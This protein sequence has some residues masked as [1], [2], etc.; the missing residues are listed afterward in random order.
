MVECRVA[1]RWVIGLAGLVAAFAPAAAS[2]Q[3]AYEAQVL[4]VL[5]AVRA[6]PAA[7]A[8]QLRTFRSYFHGASYVVPGQQVRNVT[9]EGVGAVDEAIAYLSRQRALRPMNAADT[10]AAAA[11]DHV[12]EQGEAG[13]IGHGGEDGSSPGDRVRRHGGG[14]YVAEVIEYGASDPVDA[15]R[16]LIV[17]DGVPDRGHRSILFDPSLRF[18]GVSCGRHQAY[19]SMCVI[20]FGVE[21]DGRELPGVEMASIGQ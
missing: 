15:V 10:L 21:R 14:E 17:D 1:K 8:D 7:F 18:A 16:Q 3:T 6:N 19:R 4:Q 12:A 9:N 11:A 13:S 5:N 20:D 2:A